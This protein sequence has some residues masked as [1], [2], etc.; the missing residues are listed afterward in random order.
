MPKTRKTA[1]AT[2]PNKRTKKP[3]DSEEEWDAKPL[4]RKIAIK[5]KKN[6]PDELYGRYC[7]I[8]LEPYMEKYD[9]MCNT[10]KGYCK[11]QLLAQREYERDRAKRRD[12]V[13]ERVAAAQ[14]ERKEMEMMIPDMVS[15]L[16]SPSSA[17]T[18]SAGE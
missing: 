16:S 6:N 11:V 9:S 1:I 4:K 5:K 3:T 10:Y 12:E 7:L 18:T 13:V 8:A 17:G 15:S 14:A 2:K